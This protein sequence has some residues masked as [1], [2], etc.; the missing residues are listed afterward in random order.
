[1]PKGKKNTNGLV[2]LKNRSE[3]ERRAIQSKGGKASKETQRRMKELLTDQMT[4]Q[5]YV[6]RFM[7]RRTNSTNRANLKA[8]GLE[9]DDC[10]NINSFIGKLF[11]QFMLRG[12]VRAAELLVTLGGLTKEE[13]RRDAEEARKTLES[14]ARIAALE[15][16]MGKDMSVT[17][18]DEGDGSIVIYLPEVEKEPTEEGE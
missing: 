3:E 10:I 6:R 5:D 13:L 8:L 17:S 11:N 14:K 2:S 1:M 12:D 16:N 9:D 18:E 15:A 7:C 4:M